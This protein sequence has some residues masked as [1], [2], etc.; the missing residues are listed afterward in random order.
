M[1]FRQ[2]SQEV[3]FR[4]IV[5]LQMYYQRNIF[6]RVYPSSLPEVYLYELYD[7]YYRCIYFVA[8]T[9]CGQSYKLCTSLMYKSY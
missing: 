2:F 7:N 5:Y 8:R 1:S 9:I 6:I 4:F 3:L